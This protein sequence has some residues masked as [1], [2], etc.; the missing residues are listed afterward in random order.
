GRHGK[1][2]RG[3]PSTSPEDDPAAFSREKR[4]FECPSV[5]KMLREGQPFGDAEVQDV[6]IADGGGRETPQTDLTDIQR[7]RRRCLS[8]W[9]YSE[10]FHPMLLIQVLQEAAES[11]RCIDSYYHTQDNSLFIVLHNPA[12]PYRQSQESWDMALHSNVSFRNYL[13]LVADSISNW[14]QDEEATYRERLE[15]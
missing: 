7:T 8:D 9:C 13:E 5:R 15:R 14:V 6:S 4:F 2:D 10:N 1:E 11:Y 3:R 12:N